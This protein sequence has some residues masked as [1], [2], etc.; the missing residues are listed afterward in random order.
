MKLKR[1]IAFI[2]ILSMVLA[3]SAFHASAADKYTYDPGNGK[4]VYISD[5]GKDSN[6]G[7]ENAP[8]KTLKRAF[9]A[10]S[11]STNT[12]EKSGGYIIIKDTL[13][14]FDSED[15]KVDSVK[16]SARY[17][18][19]L[20][21]ASHQ[22]PVT[23]CGA[24]SDSKLIFG[25]K[26]GSEDYRRY[27]G[28]I[29]AG[30]P[31][32][33]E[34]IEFLYGNGRVTIV[35]TNHL[36][37]DDS[38]YCQSQSNDCY[39]NASGK[40]ELFGGTYAHVFAPHKDM[41]TDLNI[42]GNAVVGT[43]WTGLGTISKKVNIGIH[44]DC[45]ISTLN[46]G[47]QASTVTGDQNLFITGGKVGTVAV[48]SSVTFKGGINVFYS[49]IP[50]GAPAVAGDSTLYVLDESDSDGVSQ[51]FSSYTFNG[52]LK[53]KTISAPSAK[54]ENGHIVKCMSFTTIDS[55]GKSAAFPFDDYAVSVPEEYDVSDNYRVY[56]YNGSSYSECELI[57]N[58]EYIAFK[59]VSSA[60]SYAL[61][62]MG[63]EPP[64]A[65]VK[66]ETVIGGID[67]IENP[68][69]G[70]S[71]PSTPG[72]NTGDTTDTDGGTDMTLIIIICII[73]V[74]VVCEIVILASGKKKAAK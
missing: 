65:P 48:Y 38:A 44:G 14:L 64:K 31:L 56:A 27:Q 59:P 15:G 55:N 22:N 21:S 34:N 39:I 49:G 72:D 11:N 9:N 36:R 33:F 51:E 43:L 25:N 74:T 54:I 50:S 45:Q 71:T 24:D 2:L 67:V 69:I 58:G 61:V 42:G 10:L 28:V 30:G 53:V 60:K 17:N 40:V 19:D 63:G 29:T 20:S 7:S 62:H 47:G 41:A 57:C 26:Y 8:F 1:S 3:M 46:L 73:A 23:I 13:T 4:C 52:A 70:T 16:D 12:K 18:L 32:I 68:L 37:V 6:D 5:S 66:A 35:S